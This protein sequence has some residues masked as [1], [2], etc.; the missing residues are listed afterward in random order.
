MDVF[1]QSSFGRKM[2]ELIPNCKGYF[3][4]NES[5]LSVGY[6]HLDEILETLKS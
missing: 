4:P 3:F 1:V 5:H 6:N 2:C